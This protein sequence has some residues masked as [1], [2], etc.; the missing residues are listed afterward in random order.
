VDT[1]CRLGDLLAQP[2]WNKSDFGGWLGGNDGFGSK[3]ESGLAFT[4][5]SGDSARV[6]GGE[7]RRDPCQ[8]SS[9]TAPLRD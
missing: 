7:R 9:N 8:H 2:P 6:S 3:Q 5:P 1:C 4:A